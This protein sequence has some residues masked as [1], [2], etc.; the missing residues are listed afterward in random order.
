M[1][2]VAGIV[3]VTENAFAMMVSRVFI[4][5][6]STA[7]RNRIPVFSMARAG[8]MDRVPAIKGLLR[9]RTARCSLAITTQCATATDFATLSSSIVHVQIPETY[10]CPRA[11]FDL[12]LVNQYVVVA[13]V[14]LSIA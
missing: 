4:V 1:E 12:V 3:K 11:C 5:K 13:A 10:T 6:Y 9:C 8:V 14:T 2:M 7:I